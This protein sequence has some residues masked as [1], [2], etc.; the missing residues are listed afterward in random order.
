[1]SMILIRVSI[2]VMT[3]REGHESVGAEDLGRLGNVSRD[4]IVR[5][6][7]LQRC[8]RYGKGNY[9]SHSDAS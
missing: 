2:M 5:H 1:M 7:P 8:I 4:M 6:R 3:G 9:S